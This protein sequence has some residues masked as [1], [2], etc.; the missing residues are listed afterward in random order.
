MFQ[1]RKS[2]SKFSQS[3]LKYNNTELPDL[4]P[5]SDQEIVDKLITKNRFKLDLDD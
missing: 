2:E 3:K 5:K 1:T 4:N